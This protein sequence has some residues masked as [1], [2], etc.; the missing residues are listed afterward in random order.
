MRQTRNPRYA[1]E[2]LERK[3]SPSSLIS[4]PVAAQVYVASSDMP[5]TFPPYD[6]NPVGGNG[7]P[8]NPSPTNPGG[9]YE[10]AL[11]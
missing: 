3:L 4:T 7:L 10:P 8:P 5:P 6:P 2:F 1:P 9:P 11:A